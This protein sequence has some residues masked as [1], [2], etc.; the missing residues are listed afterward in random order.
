LGGDFFWWGGLD[1]AAGIE[2]LGFLVNPQAGS[3]LLLTC[4]AEQVR[5]VKRRKEFVKA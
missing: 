4:Y 2:D 5:G 3:S 1:E